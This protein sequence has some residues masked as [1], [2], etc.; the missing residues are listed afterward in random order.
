V[1]GNWDSCSGTG[2]YDDFGAGM[3]VTIRDQD[4]KI[5]A[6]AN[7]Q[8]L[9]RDIMSDLYT[10]VASEMDR[11]FGSSTMSEGIALLVDGATNSFFTFCTVYYEA[12]VPLREFYEIEVGSRGSLAYSKSE[13]EE[14]SFV[15]YSSLGN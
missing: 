3:D 12:E 7:T 5:V 10:N 13:L 6:N 2:G 11:V 14:F 9:D 1:I 4:G 8:S 15:V